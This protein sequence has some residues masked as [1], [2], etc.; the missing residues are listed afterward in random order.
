MVNVGK[1]TIHGCYGIGNIIQVLSDCREHIYLVKI[2][3]YESIIVNRKP[4]SW[5]S[6][7]KSWTS[8]PIVEN[9]Q[10]IIS[11]MGYYLVF[12]TNFEKDARQFGSFPQGSIA[13]H[14]VNLKRQIIQAKGPVHHDLSLPIYIYS[15]LQVWCLVKQE[16][17][18]V[19]KDAFPVLKDPFKG[20][21]TRGSH[22]WGGSFAIWYGSKLSVLVWKPNTTWI[23]F[24]DFGIRINKN[25]V[26]NFEPRLSNI[27]VN[28]ELNC[29]STNFC[30][31]PFFHLEVCAKETR[32]S[33]ED[34]FFEEKIGRCGRG[35]LGLGSPLYLLRTQVLNFRG[36]NGLW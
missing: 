36:V 28:A 26:K 27:W 20:K 10:T 17:S 5:T 31:I 30:R 35:L 2:Q 34:G 22:S 16:E 23:R 24:I 29:K 25:G 32:R 33:L 7:P 18:W 21:M 3:P 13:F 12:L 1:Y 14:S 8:I 4:K 15:P 19:Q 6:I 9:Y 11:S